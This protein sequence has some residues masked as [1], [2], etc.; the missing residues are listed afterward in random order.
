MSVAILI[1]VLMTRRVQAYSGDAFVTKYAADGTKAWTRLLGGTDFDGGFALTTG[2]DGAIYVS[3]YTMSSFDGQTNANAGSNSDAFITKYAT[4][5]T[6][7]WTTFLGGTGNDYGQALTTGTDGTIYVTGYT[8]GNFDGQTNAGYADAFVSKYTSDGTK[9]WTT[10]LGGTSFDYGSALTT[11]TDG[12]IYVSGRTWSSFDGQTNA[13]GTDAFLTKYAADGTKAWTKFLGGTGDEDARAL[14]T[15][16]DGAIYVGGY[17]TSSFDGQTNAGGADAFVTKYAA[18]GTK[19]WTKLLGGTDADYGNALT[20]GTDGSIY[21]SGSTNNSFDGQTNAGGLDAFVTKYAADGTKAWTQLLG[22]TSED[23]GNALTSGTDSAIYVG[24]RTYSSFDGQT[25]AGLND[26]FISKFAFADTTAPTATA[27]TATIQNS[28]NAVVQSSETGTAYLVKDTVTVTDVA[29][30]TSAADDNFNAVSI[31]AA[32]TDTNLAATGLVDG[33]YKVYTVDA[34]GNLSAVSANSI[35]ISTPVVDTTAPTASVST[36]TI[37]NSSN[38]VVQSSETGTAY[39]VKDTVTVTDVAAITSAAD[40]NFNAVSITAANTDTNLA[41]TGLVDGTYKVYTVDAAGNLSAVSANS[42]VISTSVVD[43]TPPTVTFIMGPGTI[44]QSSE[45]GTAYLVKNS[46]VVNSLSDITSAADNNF[47]SVSITAANTDTSIAT[48]GLVDGTYYFYSVDAAGNLSAVSVGNIIIG[49][50]VAPVTPVTPPTTPTETYTPPSAPPTET[51][52]PPADTYSP[53]SEPVLP[54]TPE[55]EPIPLKSYTSGVF[56]IT[57][58]KPADQTNPLN[59]NNAN[60]YHGTFYIGRTDGIDQMLLVDGSMDLTDQTIQVKGTVSSMMGAGKVKTQPL[61]NGQFTIDTKTGKTDDFRENTQLANDYTLGGLP[62]TFSGLNITKDQLTFGADFETDNLSIPLQPFSGS[63][64]L[65]ITQNNVDFGNSFKFSTANFK[66]EN[67]MG[68]PVKEFSDFSISYNAVEESIK[69]QGKLVIGGAKSFSLTLDLTDKNYITWQKQTG[70]EFKGSLA[71]KDIELPGGFALKEAKFTADTKKHIYG[72]AAKVHFPTGFDLGGGVEF[73]TD[74]SFAINK[75]SIAADNLNIPIPLQPSLFLQK[76]AASANNLSDPK[77][78]EWGGT[79]GFTL[80]PKRNVYFSFS[81]KL[82]NIDEI[83]IKDKSFMNFDIE[84]TY[85]SEKI[86]GK[87]TV[88]LFDDSLLKGV[89]DMTYDS[90]TKSA[91]FKGNFSLLKD[92]VKVNGS[93]KID[94]SKPVSSIDCQ[95]S[96]SVNIPKSVPYI[97]GAQLGSAN[98]ITHFS[99]DNNYS[100]D[101]TAAWG[102][103][104]VQKLGLDFSFVAGFKIY[105][106]GKMETIGSKN[107]PAV[108]ALGSPSALPS[109]KSDLLTPFSYTK[110]IGFEVGAESKRIFLSANWD[111]SAQNDTPVQVTMPNGTVVNEADFTAN[112]IAVIDQLSNDRN[113]TLV[114]IN[115]QPGVWKMNL[116]DSTKLGAVHYAASIDSVVPT[117]EIAP[118]NIN[119]DGLVDIEYKGLDSDSNANISF[120]YDTDNQEFNGIKIVEDVLENDDTAH[121]IWNT[122]GVAPG[123]YFIY[124]MIMDENN[125][126]IFT[127]SPNQ[128]KITKSV[129]LS[130]NQVMTVNTISDKSNLSYMITVTNNGEIESKNI[131]LNTTIPENTSLV[132]TSILPTQLEN[133]IVT[134]NVGNLAGHTSK[135]FTVVTT[136]PKMVEPKAVT[137]NSQIDS[138]TF[139]TDA[140]NNIDGFDFN[141]I[142]SNNASALPDGVVYTPS[143]NINQAFRLYKAAFDRLPD[144]GGL[145]YWIN[146]LNNGTVLK[147]IAEGF[148]QSNEFASMYDKDFVPEKFVSKVYNHVLHRAYEQAGFNFWVNT[149]KSGAN[150]QADVLAQFGESTENKIAVLDLVGIDSSTLVNL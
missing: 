82:L 92:I 138:G 122:E 15:G 118:I 24:G 147:S 21:V 43:T 56:I 87:A 139:D 116:V 89:G 105:F 100:N 110:P 63:D 55:K 25:N 135:T 102:T 112:N 54:V 98:S 12:A 115:P 143:G 28:D 119:K 130:V 123:D 86:T 11:G 53:P 107:I 26:V 18:D 145:N 78:T 62:V 36:A 103:I 1:V 146:V 45:T 97:G 49:T 134:F 83:K 106:D 27:T 126:P 37:Q 41:A 84:G 59:S 73:K 149:I 38:A 33:T 85:S 128:V 75:V 47:N 99:D 50:L 58:I 109:D 72:L 144:A 136:P 141:I 52:V 101:F 81:S 67:L 9:A 108:K 129:D 68:L 76:F 70:I 30:I 2:T 127:Y 150:S 132:S 5:G 88:I 140:L 77:P 120:F 35:V 66:N 40:D 17:T 8:F 65:I 6:K 133:N 121:F 64:A 124:A 125:Q 74:P 117:I 90:K 142:S 131:V 31:T 34:A 22:E 32:N 29:S 80:G 4:D 14:T 48:T 95:G 10:F 19:A 60:A 46:V 104:N 94:N 93:F 69:L 61:L 111:N 23:V 114:V 3:G 51:Y 20:T 7:A 39:L 148:V 44:V 96:A 137:I 113:K 79:L 57:P 71:V 91:E 16:T 42:I 13:G